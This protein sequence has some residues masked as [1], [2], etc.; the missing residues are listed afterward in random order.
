MLWFVDPVNGSNSNSGTTKESPLKDLSLFQYNNESQPYLLHGDKIFIKRGTTLQLSNYKFYTN[1]YNEKRQ[2]FTYVGAYGVGDDP[3]LTCH[4]TLPKSALSETTTTNVY[5]VDLVNITGGY[6]GAKYNF[7]FI[8]DEENDIMYGN[9]VFALAGL[10]KH[11]DF[12][13]DETTLYVYVNDFDSLPEQ[14]ILG[15]GSTIMTANANMVYEHL[16]FK[17]GGVHGMNITSDGGNYNIV[18]KNCTFEKLGGALLSG[19]TRYGNGFEIYGSASDVQVQNCLFK[20]IY[21]TG[22]TY[23]GKNATIEN[24]SFNHNV[25]I[26]CN[27]ACENWVDNSSTDNEGGYFNCTFNHNLCMLSGYGFGGEG[28]DL[29]YHFMLTNDRA[30]NTEI[31]VRD[32][33]F[34]KAKNGC[35][36][37][38]DLNQL[39][40]MFKNNTIYLYDDQKINYAYDYVM[41]DYLNYKK[42]VK[43]D[44]GSKFL[45][46]TRDY[47]DTV[48]EEILLSSNLYM[49]A[50]EN[51]YR[52]QNA[53]DDFIKQN[54]DITVLEMQP[55]TYLTDVVSNT[56]TIIGNEAHVYIRAT[57]VADIPQYTTFTYRDKLRGYTMTQ[58]P[59][60][61]F[62]ALMANEQLYFQSSNAITSGTKITIRGVLKLNRV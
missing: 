14:L 40:L 17:Y 52:S 11:M 2:P 13:L 37:T 19:T 6:S 12:Y 58:Q 30:I 7:G 51:N 20:D 50:I 34:F 60:D 39:D 8:Y 41:K 56:I 38:S 26:R 28:R 46:L 33:V 21:D 42:N 32:N 44:K 31:S 48:L 35:Y 45:V 57:A 25:F 59:I 22:V 27:Q 43:Q 61:S 47:K 10:I 29:G 24:V 53:D 15:V 1:N 55:T 62:Y 49:N 9:R 5:A 16:H 3:V 18:V 54:N 23:Q 36:Y 4:K